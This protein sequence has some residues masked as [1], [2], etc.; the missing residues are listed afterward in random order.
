[1]PI[2]FHDQLT[3][4]TD[5]LQSQQLECCGTLSECEQ[6]ERITQTM[7]AQ[8]HVNSEIEKTLL[9]VY[10]YSQG[11]QRHENIND[12][13]SEH[14]EYLSSWINDLQNRQLL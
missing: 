8:P 3:L 11:G 5:I 13:V 2:Q 1:M 4:L 6:L 14:K 10:A 7:L 12:Y 9:E